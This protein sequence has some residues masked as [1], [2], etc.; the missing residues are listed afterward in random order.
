MKYC[1]NCGALLEDDAIFC[2]SCGTK[3]AAPNL[4]PHC[5]YEHEP[6][7]AFCTNCGQRFATVSA[8]EN[9]HEPTIASE[10]STSLV[11]ASIPESENASKSKMGAIALIVLFAIAI[12]GVG[13]YFFS[14]HLPF[15]AENS[16]NLVT[17]EQLAE[18]QDAAADE[19]QTQSINEPV[20]LENFFTSVYSGDDYHEAVKS[21]V[22]NNFSPEAQQYL[23]DLNDY[24]GQD[25]YAIWKIDGSSDGG[26]PSDKMTS[27]M[28][29]YHT[30]AQKIIR[31]T[32]EY[33]DYEGTVEG[34]YYIKFYCHYDLNAQKVI[35]DSFEIE[36]LTM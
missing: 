3:Q 8:T 22:E 31:L 23:R 36:D 13:Y 21:M 2:T 18:T 12:I 33:Y 25:D 11:S 15:M 14:N 24:E 29:G 26:C 19:Q 34:Y 32:F 17:Q 10:V 20:E 35:I 4:C 28:Y 5:G 1:T 30:E 27:L 7:A 6:D 9:Q 16:E